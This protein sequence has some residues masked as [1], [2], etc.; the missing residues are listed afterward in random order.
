M[1][2]LIVYAHPNPQSFCKGIV[3]RAYKKSVD[4]GNETK[5]RDLYSIGFNP[6]LSP[7]DFESFGRGEI[8]KDIKEEQDLISWADAITFVYPIWWADK[9]A[10]LKGYIDRVFSYGFAYRYGETGAEGLLKGK[11][12]TIINTS[13]SSNSDYEKSGMHDCI[14]KISSKGTFEFC[15]MKV[16]NHVFFGEVPRVDDDTRA[17]YLEGVDQAIEQFLK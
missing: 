7:S 4:M 5:V 13:G 10:I 1:K 6:V 12:V 17:G 16:D 8:P 14:K 15:G 2:H 3:D 11:K 9:P